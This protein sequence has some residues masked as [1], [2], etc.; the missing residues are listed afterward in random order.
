MMLTGILFWVLDR[1][2]D[3]SRTARNNGLNGIV[4]SE[5]TGAGATEVAD[6][7]VGV[8]GLVR[9]SVVVL[10]DEG[11]ATLATLLAEVVEEVFFED[12]VLLPEHIP[13]ADWQPAL[14][15]SEV[16]PHWNG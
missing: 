2:T 8:V 9:D 15:W 12:E 10:K 4:G 5:A 7:P 1:T 16:L 3:G 14:Q 13:K 6:V 11:E